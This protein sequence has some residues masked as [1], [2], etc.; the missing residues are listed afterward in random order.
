M[1]AL[2][3]GW[4]G[5]QSYFIRK[6]SSSLKLKQRAFPQLYQFNRLRDFKTLSAMTEHFVLSYTEYPD[7]HTYLSGY[8]I[9]GDRLSDLRIPAVML[10]AEDDPVIPFYGLQDMRPSDFLQV[11]RS[12]KGGHCGFISDMQLNSWV[13]GFILRQLDAAE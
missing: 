8:A 7:L 12:E 10:L 4:S 3:A 5:Y 11:Y 13:D 2:D 1:I 6:W 9:T